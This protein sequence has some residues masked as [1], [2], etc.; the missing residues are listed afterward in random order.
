MYI[1]ICK[2]TFTTTGFQ[3]RSSGRRW[4]WTLKL[5]QKRSWAGRWSWAAKVGLLS[6]RVVPQQ[7]CNGHCPCDSAQARQLKQQLRGALVAAQWRGDTASSIVLAA[8][9]GLSGLFRAVSAVEPSLFRLFMLYRLGTEIML[10]RLG[11]ETM[12]YRLGTETMLYR[13][14]TEIMLYRLGTCY[15]GWGLRS[16]YTDWGLRSCYTDW[17]LTVTDWG[18]TRVSRLGGR[19]INI[20]HQPRESTTKGVAVWE[21]KECVAFRSALGNF[22]LPPAPGDCTDTVR[23][24][25][26]LPPAPGGCTDTVRKSALEVDSG[27][28][29]SCRTGD[30]NPRQYCAWLFSRRLCQLNYPRR[31]TWEWRNCAVK[32]MTYQPID[33]LRPGDKEDSFTSREWGTDWLHGD[34]RERLC[35][36]LFLLFFFFCFFFYWV[37]LILNVY[38]LMLCLLVVD[39][40]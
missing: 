1:V 6:L 25:F 26:L 2:N 16:C 22:L 39:L 38:I 32:L 17:G 14:G 40:T 33:W 10:Y 3:A 29:I 28:K 9:R 5:A 19:G 31:Q 12:L 20:H 23:N 15:T 11:T 7:Q 8:V 27:R 30:S 13:L 18:L 36:F 37:K 34:F 35:C 4:S 21:V 24:C